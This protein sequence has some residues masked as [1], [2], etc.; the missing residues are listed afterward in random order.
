MALVFIVLRMNIAILG[1]NSQIAK[2]LISSF[3]DEDKNKVLY[4]FTRQPDKLKSWMHE[5]N[6]NNKYLATDYGSFSERKYDAIIN[7]VGIGDPKMAIDMGPLIFDIT[8][9]YDQMAL[10]YLK[11]NPHCKYIFLSS[12]A[13]Y[14]DVFNEPANEETRA[15]IAINKLQSSNW[16]SIAKLYA[17]ARHRALKDFPIVDIRVFNYFSHTQYMSARFLL[18]DIISAIKNKKS[19]EVSQKNIFRDYIGPRD[20]CQLVTLILEG[21]KLNIPF[22]CY[23]NAPIDKISLLGEMHKNFGLVYFFADS[24]GVNATG[25]K[26]HYYSTNFKA[27]TIGYA[28]KNTS[29]ENIIFEARLALISK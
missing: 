18:T 4:L 14:G 25:E 24:E 29:L 22:D 16:Y 10:D 9:E 23:S 2:D 21:P 6:I 15:S 11:F 13:V 5:K 28:P 17:E 8:L 3:S 27:R 1:A 12:G 7:F 19:L 20:F 26:T